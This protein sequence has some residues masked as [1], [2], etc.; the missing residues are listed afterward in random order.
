MVRLVQKFSNNKLK[1][2]DLKKLNKYLKP[3][4]LREKK[5]L[6]RREQLESLFLI[7]LQLLFRMINGMYLINNGFTDLYNYVFNLESNET[8]FNKYL[9]S[10]ISGINIKMSYDELNMNLNSDFNIKNLK[11]GKYILRDKSYIDQSI[12]FLFL[13][14]L[15]SII[16]IGRSFNFFNEYRKKS[17]FLSS[18]YG[19]GFWTIFLMMLGFSQIWFSIESSNQEI[20]NFF[21]DN[22]DVLMEPFLVIK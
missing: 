22:T 5:F 21:V 2:V 3:I 19:I 16:N 8:N 4:S 20:K 17:E 12:Y 6:K 11:D 15:S 1:N 7:Y 14:Q 13:E 18:K 10:F 9:R